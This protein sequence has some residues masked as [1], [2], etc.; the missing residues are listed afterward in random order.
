MVM[1]VSNLFSRL[2]FSFQKPEVF[3]TLSEEEKARRAKD[4]EARKLLGEKE[5]AKLANY[6]S[7]IIDKPLIDKMMVHCDFLCLQLGSRK[8]GRL[9]NHMR[10]ILDHCV[11]D[12][13]HKI[14]QDSQKSIEKIIVMLAF[15]TPIPV[16]HYMKRDGVE[17]EFRDHF[18]NWLSESEAFNEEETQFIIDAVFVGVNV[19]SHP[20]LDIYHDALRI[21][22]SMY[23]SSCDPDLFRTSLCR[24][25]AFMK[26]A[27]RLSESNTAPGWLF[28]YQ[29]NVGV[30]GFVDIEKA[31]DDDLYTEEDGIS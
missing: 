30:E 5:N 1:A 26:Y 3:S 8:V 25:K 14:T 9:I 21:E 18:K 7:L 13:E 31:K 17:G 23:G 27:G 12:P 15:L 22:E 11:H 6:V 16:K 28:Y 24:N 19:E 20:V 2:G 29:E 10:A 4:E